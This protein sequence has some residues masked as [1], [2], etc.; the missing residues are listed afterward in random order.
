M[1]GTWNNINLSIKNYSQVHDEDKVTGL[2]EI[3][4]ERFVDL[5]GAGKC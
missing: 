1:E 4:N 5:A 2:T 3:P